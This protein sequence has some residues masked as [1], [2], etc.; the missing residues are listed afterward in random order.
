[1]MTAVEDLFQARRLTLIAGPCVIE[2]YEMCRDLAAGILE[3]ADKH[4]IPF[5]FKASFDKANRTSLASYRGPGLDEGLEI[6]GRVRQEAGVPVL[7]DIHLPEQALPAAQVVDVLQTPAFLCRQTDL[8]TAAA[9]T[10]K[11]TNI[12]KGQFVAPEDMAHVVDK[13]RA[14]G[15][16]PVAVTERGSAFGYHNLVV[17]MRS[18]D[19]MRRVT[20]APIIFDATHSVQHP[21]AADGVTGGD[22]EL[23]PL[24]ARAAAAVGIDGLFC[25]V[26]PDPDRAKS[27]GPNSLTLELLDRM[28]AQ[29]VAIDGARRKVD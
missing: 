5:I 27:D 6:L 13:Y 19:V 26:H 12:K 17:D 22:R 14:S 23:A 20:G 25:E 7:T 16:G 24:L 2:S 3:R 4:G 18:L 11:P 21:S 10:G 8:I 28:L 1:M 15:G 9:E 29:V